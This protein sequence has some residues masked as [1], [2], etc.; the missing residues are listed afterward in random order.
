VAKVYEKSR[1][2]EF[3]LIYFYVP[4]S[5][6]CLNSA[7]NSLRLSENITVFVV[8]HT[9]IY[10]YIYIQGLSAKRPR[11]TPGV[12]DHH[13]VVSSCSV[14]G[15]GSGLTESIVYN[16]AYLLPQKRVV[17]RPLHRN[18]SLFNGFTACFQC[19]K[20]AT[21]NLFLLYHNVIPTFPWRD[22]VIHEYFWQISWDSN[23]TPLNTS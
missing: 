14:Y 13:S 18:G 12:W 22:W 15:L 17:Y 20:L 3:I 21:N 19:R 2:L 10:I 23:Q 16:S 8:Y 11:W 4:V 6:S 7:E 5:T 1:W 9:Y